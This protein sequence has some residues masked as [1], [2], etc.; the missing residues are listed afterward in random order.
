MR[1][2]GGIILALSLAL[3]AG[4]A[5]ARAPRYYKLDMRPSGAVAAGSVNLRIDR[6]RRAEPLAR[7][8]LLIQRTPTEVEYYALDEW[9]A[10]LGEMVGQKLEAEF[11][12]E[13]TGKPVLCLSGSIL[14]FD[15]V[16]AS[17]GAE[18]HIRLSLEFRAGDAG[19]YDTPLLKKTYEVLV[20]AARPTP[21]A[22]VEALSRGVERIA[23]QIAADAQKLV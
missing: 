17:A 14:N 3:A 22:V 4:C 13:D 7:R 15:Q 9:A 10:D 8:N 12:V 20:P 21:G 18:A 1:K 2:R 11:G 19:R 5:A 6:L 16:D 23:A